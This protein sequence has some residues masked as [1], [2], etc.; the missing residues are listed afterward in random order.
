MCYT[1]PASVGGSVLV[2]LRAPKWL[3][4]ALVQRDI[5]CLISAVAYVSLSVLNVLSA[6]VCVPP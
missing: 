4:P 1:E 5:K 3:E 2:L 6:V